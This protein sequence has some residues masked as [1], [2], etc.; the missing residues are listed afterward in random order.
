MNESEDGDERPLVVLGFFG[1]TLDAP[2]K[3]T[4]WQRWRPT[5]SIFGHE[6]LLVD[7]LELLCPRPSQA[8]VLVADIQRASPQ[9]EVRL[10]DFD[11]SNA[12]DFP[13]VYAALHDFARAYPFDVE[14]ERYLIHLTTGTHV[15]QICLFLLT[16]TRFFPARLLQTGP[17]RHPSR[18]PSYEIIDLDLSRYDS[19]AQR[20]EE[21]RRSRAGFL[22]SG[23]AT[24]NE[25]FNA[26]MAQVERVASSS[27]API[28]LSGPT[29]SGKTRLARRI[30]ALKQAR[31]LASKSFVEV[32]CATLRGDQAMS[33][34]FG[35]RRG[36]F[37]GAVADHKG[38]LA[39]ADSGVLFLDEIGELGLDEQAMLLSAIEDKR[40]TPVGAERPIDSD[41]QLIA[42]SNRDLLADVASGRFRED[43]LA[44]INLWSFRLPAL[45]ERRED[46]APNVDFELERIARETDRRVT[47]SKEA[48]A[49]FLRF[50]TDP[51]ASWRNN[52]R[53][54]SAALTRMSTLAAGGRIGEDD[55]AAEVAR[56]EA[57]WAPSAAST[58]EDRLSRLLSEEAIAELD[59]FD[60]HQLAWV[61]EVCS[62]SVSLSA[63]GR[64]LFAKSRAKKKTT[65]DA[66]RVR[67]YLMRF[68]VDPKRAL[69]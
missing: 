66:D 28:L 67:K 3:T 48:R 14:R 5:Y 63:A 45:R 42:G 56:L 44:R 39:R 20:F 38:L 69:G 19:I 64:Q 51:A 60:R 23:I 58:H 12:W 7:R 41:F 13:Q 47:F 34:L 40:F 65:N 11:L 31:G 43:L 50:A 18:E 53:D 59:P 35:H 32:N 10:H 49:S 2:R 16:E 33:T 8:D 25:S 1:T 36:A 54:L 6:D 9:T 29:G 55:V 26:L 37:T 68:G 22:K 27:R 15:A 62:R 61:L 46:I 30:H 17:P 57:S 21:E 52:F 24:R 4:R